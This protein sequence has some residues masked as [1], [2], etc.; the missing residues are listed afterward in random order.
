MAA[1]VPRQAGAIAIRRIGGS[2]EV[3]LIRK[4]ESKRWGIPKGIIDPGNTPEETALIE[5]E[6]EA[7]LHGRLIGAPLGTYRFDKWDTTFTVVV[8]LMEVL[9]Q[10]DE[11]DEV[12]IRERKWTS[13]RKAA[14]LLSSHPVRPL[15]DHAARRSV[16]IAE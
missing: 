10:E 15:L 9:A 12:D 8:Y 14:S 4:R 11:W 1:D 5:A 16:R 7:G 13:F 2:L 3:C 6:E